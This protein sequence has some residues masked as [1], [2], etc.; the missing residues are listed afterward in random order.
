[1][2][3]VPSS[4]PSNPVPRSRYLPALPRPRRDSAEFSLGYEAYVV[5][6]DARPLPASLG[7][8]LTDWSRRVRRLLG[9]TGLRVVAT[10]AVVGFAWLCERGGA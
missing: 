10:V 5:F 3:P 7:T 2:R 4:L 8:R 9:E 1:M 6:P